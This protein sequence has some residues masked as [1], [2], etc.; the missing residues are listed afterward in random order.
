[1]A[2]AIT[3]S[4]T[5]SVLDIYEFSLGN[6]P[7]T[8]ELDSPNY[9]L[10]MDKIDDNLDKSIYGNCGKI[11]YIQNPRIDTTKDTQNRSCD[12]FDGI[13]KKSDSSNRKINLDIL[14][15]NLKFDISMRGS[16]ILT[17]QELFNFIQINGAKISSVKQIQQQYLSKIYVE[18]FINDLC[19]D[20]KM[21]F[22]NDTVIQISARHDIQPTQPP[23]DIRINPTQFLREFNT[24]R[25]KQP[26]PETYI[27]ALQPN[28]H[29]KFIIMGD[30]HGSFHTLVRNIF[31]F[32]A[33]DILDEQF[34]IKENHTIIFLG[35]ILD[36][37]KYAYECFVLIALLKTNNPDNIY[38]TVI[39]IKNGTLFLLSFIII[40]ILK[41]NIVF[42]HVN[43]DKI[44]NKFY[45]LFYNIHYA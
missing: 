17:S 19:T 11:D 18:T 39:L 36:R 13:I 33:M 20:L 26:I 3:Q 14:P 12:L 43:Y 41:I 28:K 32:R 29:E 31:R 5:D 42:Y 23:R 24:H 21:C 2:T 22:K 30:L 8:R 45:F 38:I 10:I 6:Y 15:K 34:K 44:K 37:G 4:M 25:M 7:T 27:K 35:D 9:H 40:F 16:I 1:M